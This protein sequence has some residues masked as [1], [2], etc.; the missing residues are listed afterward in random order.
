MKIML[1]DLIPEKQKELLDYLG[2]ETSIEGNYNEIPLFV[3]YDV[4][5]NKR[6]SLNRL[7]ISFLTMR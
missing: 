6:G 2:L 3:L 1:N 7:V 4:E 5:S